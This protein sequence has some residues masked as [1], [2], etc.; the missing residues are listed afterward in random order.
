MNYDRERLPNP[1]PLRRNNYQSQFA[2]N[3][4]RVGSCCDL[5]PVC[6]L[7]LSLLFTI[8]KGENDRGIIV[9]CSHG[10]SLPINDGISQ[11]TFFSESLKLCYPIHGEFISL[12]I[13]YGRGCMMWNL[14][15]SCAFRQLVPDPHD[16]HLQG[17]EWKRIFYNENRFIFGM[18]SPQAC[19]RTNNALF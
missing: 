6:S 8:H 11:D 13:K 1:R 4:Q 5:R 9:D 12:L 15:L 2:C 17:Y 18:M 10:G 19:Q 7:T 14:D 16:F 3:S